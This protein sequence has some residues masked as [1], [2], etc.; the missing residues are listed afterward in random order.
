MFEPSPFYCAASELPLKE[1]GG[2]AVITGKKVV[3]L[4]AAEQKAVL[5][6]GTEIKYDKCLIATGGTP[7][8]GMG[9]LTGMWIQFVR[10]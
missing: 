1:N 9:L 6:D 10:S 2:V 8:F 3:R 7:R 5:D 4:D